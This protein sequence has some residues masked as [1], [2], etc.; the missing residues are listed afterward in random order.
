MKK[1]PRRII[2]V[3]LAVMMTLSVFS[4]LG[5][6]SSAAEE[7]PPYVEF[8]SVF[9]PDTR[10]LSVTVEMQNIAEYCTAQTF[11]TFDT[12]AVSFISS[13]NR[14]ISG[15]SVTSGVNDADENYVSAVTVNNS[16]SYNSVELADFK[17]SIADGVEKVYLDAKYTFTSETLS[18]YNSSSSRELNLASLT[19]EDEDNYDFMFT[20]RSD[21]TLVLSAYNGEKTEITVPDSYD[22]KAVTAVELSAFA[23][24]TSIT[25]ITLPDT[26]TD[27]TDFSC[28]YYN[29]AFEGCTSLKEIN[30]PSKIT[31]IDSYM[32][33]KCSSLEKIVLPLGVTRIGDY[34]F[35]SCENLKE[36]SIPESVRSVGEG[37]FEYCS[38]LKEVV[39]PAGL[40]NIADE[41]FYGCTALEKVT[42]PDS[43][44]EIGYSAFSNCSA[45]KN[46]EIPEYVSTM[47]SYA[48]DN[49]T[50]LESIAIP[51][52]AMSLGSYIFSGCE[53]LNNI[54]I[55]DSVTGLSASLF[56]DTAYYK[57]EK[58]WADGVL[59][60]GNHLISAKPDVVSGNYVIPEN[61]VSISECAFRGC[62]KLTG[63]TIPESIHTIPSAA[64]SG[65]TA[66]DNITIP[67]SIAYIGS[68]AFS[69]CKTLKSVTIPDS[70]SKIG[71]AAFADCSSL[72]EINVPDSVGGITAG[73]VA[74]TAFYADDANWDGDVLYV[75][76]HLVTCK[77]R[78]IE[79]NYVVREGTVSIGYGAFAECDLLTGLEI[80]ASV[81]EIGLNAFAD[82]K[83]LEKIDVKGDA[84]IALNMITGTKLLSDSSLWDNGI[85][86][87]GKTLIASDS[88][89]VK[90]SI[91][92]KDGTKR[93]DEE[94]FYLNENITGVTIPA[95]VEYIGEYAFAHCSNLKNIKIGDNV[96]GLDYTVFRGTAYYDDN[97]NW[98]DG[99][100]YVGNY[101][102]DNDFDSETEKYTVK[103]GTVA[104]AYCALAGADSL[105]E[106]TIP[107]SV[108]EIGSN[109]FSGTAVYDN[110]KYNTD[111]VVYIGNY[112][113]HA[114]PYG[115]TGA[116]SIK[117]GTTAVADH[118]FS[119]CSSLTDVS[120]PSSVKYIGTGAFN[121][122]GLKKVSLDESVEYI[123]DTAFGYVDYIAKEVNMVTD[124]T[125]SGYAGTAAEAYAGENGFRFIT[126]CRHTETQL[127]N[128][129][130]ATCEEEGYTGD[131][132][133][134]GCGD[135]L[136]DGKAVPALGHKNVDVKGTPA[137]CEKAG[138]TD[139]VKCSVCGKMTT[140]QKNIPALGH[141]ETEIKAV[142]AT[143]EKSG[144]TE[145]TKCSVCDKV[146]K[147][148]QEIPALGHKNVDVKGTAATCEKTGL[149]DGVKCS[150][151]GK[152]IKEQKSIPALGHK[153][154]TVKGNPA[155]CE[156]T[157]LTDGEKCSVC[158]KILKE[159][160]EI[161][162]LGHKF[163]KGKCT[164]CGAFD[165]EFK[166][167]V[168]GE[169]DI[170]IN[171]ETRS[172][173]NIP[174]KTSG[175]TAADFKARFNGDIE[176]PI[177]GDA[178]IYNGMKFTFNGE[179]YTVTVKGDVS[180]DGKL[181][182]SD[183][184]LILRITAKLEN[185]DEIMK[186]GADLN[187]D[188]R[189]TASEAR[190]I[191]R[192]AARLIKSIT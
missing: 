59:F 76:N 100:F 3:L 69:E 99:A 94:V 16:F 22:G 66:L 132:Y 168:S 191:L 7:D 57:N 180:P 125:V 178:L 23:G 53:K 120:I 117:D 189:I 139:G 158:G 174:T 48:F 127:K 26:I 97:A 107:T 166:L 58:N 25:K 126:K 154:V 156:K 10:E 142:P 43:V 179:E 8:N 19:G 190:I 113:I 185:A 165:P 192:F 130:D 129:K 131:T 12:D 103:S 91:K 106:V 134:T 6:S 15:F 163:E 24:N 102:L 96:K 146:L 65:C 123:G 88:E 42:I 4:S 121:D 51:E 46:I 112:L 110:E 67:S 27:F 77:N 184:R 137:T 34:A 140:E 21:G 89:K 14:S 122:T 64:F 187:S 87:V 138:L 20:S 128:V 172:V 92:I 62:E 9:D 85:L 145:G 170:I 13:E 167:E 116:L 68:Y 157:G 161:P 109:A 74:N 152:A 90:G 160:K 40:K 44:I 119:G 78:I 148:Q 115:V 38:S 188:G 182:A 28:S 104:I 1:H 162:A 111:G 72:H 151:C 75:G 173:T 55:P 33:K 17:F 136:A 84:E 47:D 135:K 143:C 153:S 105:S 54:T 29:G 35:R 108:R 73:T 149:T 186:N 2:S 52:H 164:V 79:G 147:A 86:Y 61:V 39:L 176:L 71:T 133:C 70:V 37:A 56:S 101:L 31:S 177:A 171:N 124:F 80:P 144:L 181:T 63:V 95:S 45:L 118:A 60:I 32:F 159:Q 36:I 150:V 18:D 141:K 155:S 83:L 114:D 98:A 93:I 11:F 50:V 183:A 30:I 41:L 5:F 49:C 169:N 175:M 82:S 81:A